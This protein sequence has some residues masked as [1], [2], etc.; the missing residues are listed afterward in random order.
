MR[1]GLLLS[2]T[3]LLLIVQASAAGGQ[4]CTAPPR[5]GL[6]NWFPGADEVLLAVNL[7]QFPITY[8]GAVQQAISEAS[9]A[10]NTER[11]NHNKR[12]PEFS[13]DSSL[14]N[15]H[16]I[17]Y[18]PLRGPGAPNPGCPP[19]ELFH[20][21]ALS[22]AR[23][24][25]GSPTFYETVVYGRHGC[26]GRDV[27]SAPDRSSKTPTTCSTCSCTSWGMPWVPA[28]AIASTGS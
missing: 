17:V 12:W 2:L 5:A 16:N 21:A 13:A 15:R 20:P 27:P 23:T 6:A 14:P 18:E 7:A 9:A 3:S 10:W 24:A 25:P 8:Q 4:S 26:G 11:A 28:T 1:L 19:P 22:G